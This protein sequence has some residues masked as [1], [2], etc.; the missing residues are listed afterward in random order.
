MW[1]KLVNAASFLTTP[2]SSSE[3]CYKTGKHWQGAEEWSPVPGEAASHPRSGSQEG[4]DY[5][6]YSHC[7]PAESQMP[8]NKLWMLP[9]LSQGWNICLREAASLCPRL[10]YKCPSCR[11]CNSSPVIWCC[12]PG[13]QLSPLAMLV[14]WNNKQAL[15]KKDVRRQT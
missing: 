10:S 11:P 15:E 4:Q 1:K 13:H 6:L 2:L 8:C 5:P 9:L 7:T 3:R 12:K 14:T